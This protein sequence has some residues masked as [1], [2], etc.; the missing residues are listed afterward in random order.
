MPSKRVLVLGSSR[1]GDSDFLETAIP[2]IKKLIDSKSNIAF[3]P[4]ASVDKD[5]KKHTFR[6]RKELED[7][8]VNIE[9]VLP[10]NAK[11]V[12]EKNEIIMVGGGNTFKLLHDL[13]QLELLEIFVNI[14][15]AGVPYISWSAGS[16]IAPK[17]LEQLTIYPSLCLNLLMLLIFSLSKLIRLL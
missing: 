15:N 5:Y 17:K 11:S 13:Y 9:T 1:A 7:L 10:E 2:L 14:V 12:I 16:N 6:V 3:I 4:F 8:P